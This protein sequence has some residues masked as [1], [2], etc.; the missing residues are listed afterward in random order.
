MNCLDDCTSK[1]FCPEWRRPAGL[2]PSSPSP[3]TLRL[4]PD[5]CIGCVMEN[6]IRIETKF[7][8]ECWSKIQQIL[9]GFKNIQNNDASA[10]AVPSDSFPFS[11]GAVSLKKCLQLC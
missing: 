7:D 6:P 5:S 3:Q 10:A 2:S 4:C 9:S 1:I 11:G 8:V